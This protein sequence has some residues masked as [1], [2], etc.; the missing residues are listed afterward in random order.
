MA[1]W[2]EVR[3]ILFSS[4]V[5]IFAFI[6]FWGFAAAGVYLSLKDKKTAVTWVGMT[7]MAAVILGW[8]GYVVR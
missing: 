1:L 6:T 3:N 2:Y 7:T 4:A 5:P 8:C